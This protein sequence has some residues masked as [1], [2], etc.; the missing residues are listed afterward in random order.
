MI[1]TAYVSPKHRGIAAVLLATGAALGLCGCGVAPM[2]DR[3]RLVAAVTPY[4]VEIVQ[5]N[6][7]TREQVARVRPGMTRLQV[8]DALGSPMLTDPFHGERWDFIFTIRRPGTAAQRRHV[9]AFFEGDALK[10]LDAPTDL[11]SEKEFV[12]SIDPARRHTGP[13]PRLELTEAERSAL[14]QPA[15]RPP[16]G[17]QPAAGPSRAYPPLER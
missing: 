1:A 2:V 5:G 10:R 9:V 6:A 11:P 4:R 17:T 3:D 15:S 8:R 14:P 12:A 13:A 7:L 16:A